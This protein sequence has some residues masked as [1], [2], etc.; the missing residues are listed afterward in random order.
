MELFENFFNLFSDVW[1]QG[2][3]GSNITE[4][5]IA[6]LIF[7]IFLILRGLV[8]KFVVKRLEKYVSLTTNN[9]DNSLVKSLESPVKFFPIV[10][11]FFIASN[12]INLDGKSAFFVASLNRNL[13]TILIFWTLHQI[14]EPVSFLV[15]KIEDILSKDLLNWIIKAFKILILIL[16]VASVLEIW[17][18]KIG[19]II[20]GLGLFGVAVALGAQDLFKNLISGILVL[21]EKRFK[22][23]DWIFVDGI[24]EGIVEKIGFR[25]TVVR[26]FDKSLATIPN[27]QFAEKAV[28]NYS[29]TTHRRLEMTIGL[30]YGSTSEQ[31]MKIKKD[32]QHYIETNQ[33]FNISEKTPVSVKLSDFAG[34]SIDINI[35][36]Y[37]KTKNFYEWKATKDRFMLVIK[38]IV[39]DADASFAFPSQSIYVEKMNK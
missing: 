1:Q 33:D 13:V 3:A 6:L 19:P 36:C 5:I 34:S 4:I 37:T 2:V 11:G 27:F 39:E 25:S 9:F 12:Y 38:K 21:V 31:L 29:E 18:I 17:G 35:I 23:G 24:I 7:F 30:E 16:G 15:K 10:L 28:I 26:K 14:I 20:A 8:S 32:I 22:V